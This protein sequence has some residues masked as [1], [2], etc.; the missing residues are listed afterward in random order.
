MTSWAEIDASTAA[1]NSNLGIDVA[2]L[3]ATSK[4]SSEW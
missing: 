3:G 1:R 2:A 4:P